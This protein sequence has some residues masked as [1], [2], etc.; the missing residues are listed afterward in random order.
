MHAGIYNAV[1]G[2]AHWFSTAVVFADYKAEELEYDLS[3]NVL[4]VR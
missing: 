4:R 2:E 1:H 3:N